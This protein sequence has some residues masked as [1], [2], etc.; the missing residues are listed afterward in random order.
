MWAMLESLITRNGGS[1]YFWLTLLTL[2]TTFI[3]WPS[4]EDIPVLRPTKR[5]VCILYTS[6]WRWICNYDIA[7]INLCYKDTGPTFHRH[8]WAHLSFTLSGKTAK[9]PCLQSQYCN[10]LDFDNDVARWARFHIYTCRDVT[11]CGS[12]SKEE[13]EISAMP[14][15]LR[16]R[17]VTQTIN[18]ELDKEKRRY[19]L[20]FQFPDQ[21]VDVGCGWVPCGAMWIKN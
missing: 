17:R 11:D 7:N 12:T 20:E 9:P 1:N 13:P 19:S 3:H 6:F 10:F 8:S 5:L 21:R 16:R 14:D 18:L 4:D 2:L 15:T